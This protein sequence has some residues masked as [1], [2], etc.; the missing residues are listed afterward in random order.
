[1]F[2]R[3]DETAVLT[4]DQ[5]SARVQENADLTVLDGQRFFVRGVL[6]LPVKARDAPYNI[7]LWVEVSQR[8]FE[9]I[10]ELWDAPSQSSEPPV[11]ARIAN[12][13]PFLPNT[14]GASAEL[15]LSSPSK[16]PGIYAMPAA[17]LLHDEQVHGIEAHRAL[18]YSAY[19]QP[20]V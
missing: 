19:A 9:R 18:Q 3:P 2:R 7:G 15:R 6:P 4:D 17:G 11:E 5:R 12:E 20:E 10:Y 14:V 8:S 1:M 16:R 13:L